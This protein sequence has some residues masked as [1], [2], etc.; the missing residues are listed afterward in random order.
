MQYSP[1]YADFTNTKRIK[2]VIKTV[3]VRPRSGYNSFQFNAHSQTRPS[4]KNVVYNSISIWLN[5]NHHYFGTNRFILFIEFRFHFNAFTF[6]FILGCFV[7]SLQVM[8]IQADIIFDWRVNG[9]NSM[10]YYES[11]KPIS[12]I[13]AR[14][15]ILKVYFSLVLVH[16]LQNIFRSNVC[17]A[18]LQ[19]KKNQ[20][21]FSVEISLDNTSWFYKMFYSAF[22]YDNFIITT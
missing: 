4:P 18:Q 9:L 16:S 1:V 21:R 14:F 15:A 22:I 12:Q 5:Q 17:N 20:K 3:H 7:C 19:L 10:S 8:F 11:I 6:V 13:L 2:Q